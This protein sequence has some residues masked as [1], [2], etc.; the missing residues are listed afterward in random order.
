V[1]SLNIFQ[2]GNT[3]VLKSTFKDNEGQGKTPDSVKIIFYD[4]L[5]NMKEEIILGEDNI[6]G[7]G[8]Y[9]Y[10]YQS[11]PHEEEFVNY[12]WNAKLGNRITLKRDSF[13]TKIS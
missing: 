2:S 5:W 11:K 10:D 3:I 13:R 8:S 4:R 6:R 1:N 7:E 9:F 12:E